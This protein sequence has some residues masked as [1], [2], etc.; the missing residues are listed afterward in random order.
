[1][2]PTFCPVMQRL[3]SLEMCTLSHRR[4]VLCAMNHDF[5]FKWSQLNTSWTA[6]MELVQLSNLDQLFPHDNEY[7]IS[8]GT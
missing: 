2:V 3:L 6:W 8:P 5:K 1:M 4:D 7:C